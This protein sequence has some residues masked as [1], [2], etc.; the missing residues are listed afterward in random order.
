[1]SA[2]PPPLPQPPPVP[3]DRGALVSPPTDEGE[4][5]AERL[6]ERALLHRTEDTRTYPCLQCGGPLEWHIGQ[7]VL[8]CPFCGNEQEVLDP[9]IEV[10]EHDLLEAMAALDIGATATGPQV[11]G[12]KEV[13]CQS[14][15]GHTTF[16][17]TLTATRCPYCATPI[18]RDDV[19]AAPA[20]LAVDGILPFTVDRPAAEAAIEAWI[21]SRW[22]APKEFKEYATTGSFNSVYCAYFTY[23]A[24]TTTRYTGRRGDHYT[25]VVGSGE[26]RRTETRTRWSHAAGTVRNR[27]DD[28][29]MC[30]NEGLDR[31]HVDALEPW[32]TTEARPFNPEYLA[33]HLS[34]TYDHDV[35][36][37]FGPAKERMEDEIRH[38]VHMDIGGDVQQ[39]TSM[40]VHY[41]GLAY[42][43]L[44]LPVW[45]LTV[46][47]GGE[48]FQV[49]I[50][51]VTGEV[52]GQR[53]YSALK[54]ALAVIAVVVLAVVAYLV[55]GWSGGE[56]PAS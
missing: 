37:C 52:H 20:R 47:H 33:G 15:G 34:R 40:G 9:D 14:C 49:F 48:P 46:V 2:E 38:T 10:V 12:Q 50:N 51:G 30:A 28:L 22:F 43:H 42:K 31:R 41:E 16:T 29:P 1:M 53:P 6:R 8:K 5:A 36:T 32:P 54:I 56:V 7:Q 19:H 4:A 39:I 25:V 55:F 18:Q 26:N 45:L 3:E 13:V 21:N 35:K 27:F 24:S 44:L 11:D 23:D 17:G